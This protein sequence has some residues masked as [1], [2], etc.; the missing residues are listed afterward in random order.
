[1][2]GNHD[3]IL[4]FVVA[5]VWKKVY[6]YVWV[7]FLMYKQYYHIPSVRWGRDLWKML[8]K[9]DHS[10]STIHINLCICDSTCILLIA[11]DMGI[12]SWDPSTK[13]TRNIATWV[14]W[15]TKFSIFYSSYYIV[16]AS[17]EGYHAPTEFTE[18]VSFV[19]F[20]YSWTC[21][22]GYFIILVFVQETKDLTKATI[23][24]VYDNRYYDTISKTLP[25][26][27][28]STGNFDTDAG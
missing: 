6:F 22:V 27:S 28:R 4:T 16:L 5:K 21:I 17:T 15:L 23:R 3:A 12:S 11:C 19:F 14:Y 10:V 20:F 8:G 9:D 1:M 24:K 2:W 26:K 13:S 18:Y 7:P 25:Q